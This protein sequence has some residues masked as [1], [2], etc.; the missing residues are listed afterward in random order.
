MHDPTHH[1]N[2]IEY[3]LHTSAGTAQFIGA[4]LATLL[5]LIIGII[6]KKH[7]AR[8][9]V[10][11]ALVPSPKLSVVNLT[12][13]AIETLDRFTIDIIGEKHGRKFTP[14][15]STLFLY[16]LT[17]NLLGNIPGMPAAT[18]NINMNLGMAILVFLVY[19]FYGFKEHGAGYIKHF[20][21]P[22]WWL[23]P[24]MFV[25][26]LISH[27]VRPASLSIRLFGN[28]NGDHIAVG[29]FEALTK[30]LVPV[31]F[32]G[33]GLFVAFIQALVFTMLSAVYIQL[34]VSS[35]EH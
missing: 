22:V 7:Y 17:M 34:A 15:I 24:L 29:I 30:V 11:G 33:L 6:V 27:L 9:G 4:G 28:I 35:E 3:F 13:W 14:L 1:V 21:G 18:A 25:I 19:N 20:M 26:E 23:A 16:I 2:L 8:T 10:K 12:E 31:F 5:F 32:M